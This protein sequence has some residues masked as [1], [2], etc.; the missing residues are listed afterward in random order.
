MTSLDV[1][2]FPDSVESG[3]ALVLLML[4]HFLTENRCP[5][6]REML[7]VITR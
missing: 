2:A 7:Y 5:L 3:N 6:F 4:P 1:K